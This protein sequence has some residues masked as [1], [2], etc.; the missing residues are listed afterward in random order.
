MNKEQQRVIN[1]LLVKLL[2][3]YN[4][5]NAFYRN[6]PSDELDFSTSYPEFHNIRQFISKLLQQQKQ[7]IIEKIEQLSLCMGNEWSEGERY[8]AVQNLIKTLK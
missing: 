1:E 6:R 2:E 5:Q 7:D 4:L 3:V 8:H